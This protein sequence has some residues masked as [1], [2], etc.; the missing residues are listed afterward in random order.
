MNAGGRGQAGSA[1]ASGPYAMLP[2]S[3]NE[4]ERVIRDLLDVG[5]DAS[6]FT[7]D[8]AGSS[9]FGTPGLINETEVNQF[10]LGAEQVVKAL[11]SKLTSIL[12]CDAAASSELACVEAF[13]RTFGK[14]AFRRP[15]TDDEV[16][17]YAT[18]YEKEL[19][20]TLQLDSAAAKAA[21]LS[22]ILQSPA[23]IYHWERGNAALAKVGPEGDVPLTPYEVASRLSFF[24]WGTMPDA[25]LFAAA[26]DGTLSSPSKVE[27]QARRLLASTRSN[28][29]ITSFHR[30]W[31][32]LRNAWPR[33]ERKYPN[34]VGGTD[35]AA[36]SDVLQSL[37]H[38][39]R[40]GTGTFG[41]MLTSRVGFVTQSL[42]KAYG[43]AGVATGAAQQVTL[44]EMTR[45]NLLT[46]VGILAQESNAFDE[47]PT[48]RGVL[49]RTQ[50]LCQELAAPPADIPPLPTTAGL[51]PRARHEEH[52]KNPGCAGCHQ[53][54]D[55]VGFAFSAYDAVG[56]Y[57]AQ[58][59]TRTAD[60]KG[61]LA[62]VDGKDHVVNGP[63]DVG[64]VL[65]KSAE[66][67]AC[68]AR[69]WA[70]FALRREID[71]EASD[72]QGWE[73]IFKRFGQS[74]HDVR[75]L[76]VAIASSRSFLFRAPGAGEVM[77]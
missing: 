54:T 45:P 49:I 53:L 47:D 51:S 73:F 77:P 70:R 22:T 71:V 24:L 42:A 57:R 29:T 40:K 55:A 36:V 68:F 9:G 66:A 27:E 10:I 25:E 32:H 59:N 6:G 35:I 14:R 76:L 61:V 13:L 18:F 41:E 20:G 69:Q 38:V 67:H 75:E 17:L 15:V 60:I 26:D 11:G 2:L 62:N 21:L 19:R 74:N 44:D 3:R 5:V 48:K 64:R 56:Q 58:D 50:L 8:V 37:E 72:K 12:P 28:T 4:Y 31:L 65:L 1:A 46:R 43:I 23:F 34:W 30:Q 39:L 63:G 33:D 16:R 52:L 7:P